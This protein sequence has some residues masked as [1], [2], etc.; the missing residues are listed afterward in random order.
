MELSV[1]QLAIIIELTEVE[2]GVMKKIIDEPN[3]TDEERDDASE[4]SMQLLALSSTLQEMYKEKYVQ[5]DDEPSYELLVKSIY[6][7]RL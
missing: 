6:Q 4:H 3:S 5:G 1:S 2:I 7:R